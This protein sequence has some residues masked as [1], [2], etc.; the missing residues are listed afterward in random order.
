MSSSS[1]TCTVYARVQ[2]W[3]KLP[4]RCTHTH[5]LLLPPF[6]VTTCCFVSVLVRQAPASCGAPG[7]ELLQRSRS[8]AVAIV[9]YCQRWPHAVP[10]ETQKLSSSFYSLT[11]CCCARE[12]SWSSASELSW[13]PAVQPNS[14]W[15]STYCTSLHL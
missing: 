4:I 14:D 3:H 2:D 10:G 5:P 12:Y 6:G 11:A 8:T 9:E 7:K 15:C 13:E 1:C